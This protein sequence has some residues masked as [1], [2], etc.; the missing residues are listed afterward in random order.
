VSFPKENMTVDQALVSVVIPVYN[1]ARF[2]GRTLSSALSQT[3]NPIEVIVVDDGSTD[4]T[5]SVVESIALDDNR[6]RLLRTHR[7]GVASARN[8]GIDESRGGLIAPLD[9]DDLWHPE[10]IARQVAVM[11]SS[12]ADVGVVYCWSIEIDENDFLFSYPTLGKTTAQGRVTEE[13]AEGNFIQNSSAPLIKR[14]YIRAVGGY[15]TSLIPHGAEDWKLY[16]E[17]SSVCEFA[18]V[19]QYLVGYRQHTGSLSRDVAGLARSIELVSLWI[20]ERWPDLPEDIARKR[21]YNSSTCLAQRALDKDQFRT[22]LWYGLGAYGARP[23]ALFDRWTVAFGARFLFRL[24]G[25]RRRFF[26]RVCPRA[27]ISFAQFHSA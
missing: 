6:V 15:D 21:L 23:E 4:Q 27:A 9:A 13:L 14:S 17:L 16:L 11:N 5:A 19:T 3:Y 26:R 10:K 7:S 25:L 1:G 2:I 12:S 24:I 20:S 8:C 22:A 18:V